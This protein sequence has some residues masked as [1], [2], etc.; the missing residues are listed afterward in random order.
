MDI[1]YFGHNTYLVM[2]N[3]TSI[4]IDP[5]FNPNGAFFGS[6]FQYPINHQLA[7]KTI[8]IFR[9]TKNR[10]I[11]ISHEHLDHFDYGFL[12]KLNFD[13]TLLIPNYRGKFLKKKLSSLNHN[14]LEFYESKKYSLNEDLNIELFISDVGVNH[15]C[16]IV[17]DDGKKRF[18]N[19]N[20]CKVFD[21]LNEMGRIDYYSVQFSGANAYPSTFDYPNKIKK[22][23][24]MD[25][26]YTKIRNV[27]GALNVLDP[28]V[29]LPAAGPAIFPFLEESLSLGKGNIFVHQNFLNSNLKEAG[30]T[31]V[32]YL[33]PGDKLQLNSLKREIIKAPSLSELIEIKSSLICQWDNLPEKLDIYALISQIQSRLDNIID[34]NINDI[35]ILQF[36]WGD[37]PKDGL[38]IDLNQ[39]KLTLGY[40]SKI[41]KYVSLKA[42][43]K[44]FALMS[45]NNYRWQD[46]SLSMRA[47]VKRRPDTFNNFINLFLFSDIDNIYSSF[48]SSIEI[49]IDKCFVGYEGCNYEIDR[50]CPHQGADLSK[51]EIDKEG[52]LICPRH[53]W[54][55]N[56]N[57]EGKNKIM[58]VTI[59]AKKVADK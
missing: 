41:K 5:W 46:I 58:N 52:N 44:Y 35:P 28:T 49:P 33:R 34:I 20:D 6:W 30:W 48:I 10:Y 9:N 14:I 19:Q 42:E 2:K 40:D 23:I 18:L 22:E 39:K 15:D 55:F 54:K 47:L 1:T 26:A 36:I 21:R 8:N 24:S 16:A 56:L 31:K 4:L 27:I 43:E 38:S 53:G 59:N 11:F 12:S 25:R 13:L 7:D 51:G 29:F 3:E 32:S 37:N 17:V 50:Y 57:D 45:S